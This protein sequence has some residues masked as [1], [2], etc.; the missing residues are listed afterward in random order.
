MLLVLQFKV[1]HI[2]THTHTHANRTLAGQTSCCG[3]N[4]A[5]LTSYMTMQYQPK[6]LFDYESKRKMA[7]A[8]T[9][10]VFI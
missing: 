6:M 4:N 5:I 3:I 8:V 7:P 1:T 10:L 2:H 9:L